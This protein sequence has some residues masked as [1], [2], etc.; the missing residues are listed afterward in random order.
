MRKISVLLLVLL[1]T[2]C[3]ASGLHSVGLNKEC[4]Q[5]CERYYRNLADISKLLGAEVSKPIEVT[6][7]EPLDCKAKYQINDAVFELYYYKN[8]STDEFYKAFNHEV[9]HISNCVGS[10]CSELNEFHHIGAPRRL[11]VTCKNNEMYIN[12]KGEERTKQNIS[13]SIFKTQSKYLQRTWV[14][15][16]NDLIQASCN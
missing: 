15:D 2:G 13:C 14:C 12:D 4:V 7:Y 1:L 16:F 9:M 11:E 6:C 8:E 5:E 3:S 10:R